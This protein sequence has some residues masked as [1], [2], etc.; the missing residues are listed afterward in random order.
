MR[1]FYYSFCCINSQFNDFLTQKIQK[2]EKSAMRNLKKILALALALVMSLSLMATANAFTDDDSITDTYET[3][4]TVLSG[5]KVFQGYDD[6]SFLPQGAITRAEVAAIIYRIVTGDVADTQVGI[7]ADY[8]KFDDVASTSWYAGYVNFCANAEYIKGYDARTFGPNDPVTGYQALAMI[9]RALGYDKNGEFTGTNWTIQTAAV[10]EQRGI[11]KNIT[12]GT[13]NVP[14]TRE[15]VAEILFRAILVNT[16]NY[17]PAFGYRENE[18]SLGWETF[19]LED[20]TGA[21]VLALSDAGNVTFETGDEA[22]IDTASKFESVTGLE[23]T[24]TTEQFVNFDGGSTYEASDWRIEYVINDISWTVT[25][26]TSENAEAQFKA[27]FGIDDDDSSVPGTISVAA[28]TTRNQWI[29]T[30]DAGANAAYE[31]VIRPGATIT[32]QDMNC[33]REIFYSADRNSAGANNYV[34]GEVY[35]GTQSTDDISDDADVSWNIFVDRYIETSENSVAIDDNVNGNWLKAIDNDGDGEAEYVLQVIYTVAGVQDISNSGTITLSNE[36]D[37]LTDGDAVNEITDDNAIVTEDELA[38]GDIVYYAVIDGN[39]Y[40]YLADVVTAEIDRVNRNDLSATTTDGDEYIESGVHEHT[41][42]DEIISGVR[43]LEGDVNYDLYLDRFGYLAAFTESDNNAGFVLLTDGYYETGRTEDTFAAMVWDREAQELV[44]TDITDGGELFIDTN[45]DDNDWGNLSEFV[46]INYSGAD[47]DIQTIVAALGEDG[48]LIPVDEV[49]RYRVN[50]AMIDMDTT[51][52]VRAHTENG[53]IYSTTRYGAYEQAGASVDVRALASTVYY[54]VYNTPLGNT[55]VREYVG[56][57]NIPDLGK[58]VNMI[59][60]VYV[61]GTRAEDAYSTDYYTAEIVVVELKDGYTEIDSEQVFLYD[62]PVAGSG[63]KYE[64][65]SVIRADGTVGTV[66]IDL[67]KSDFRSYDPA[68]GKWED[69]DVESTIPGLY[70]MWESDVADVYVVRPMTWTEIANSNYVVGTVL[71]D[72]ATGADD[73]TSFIAY[74]N[75]N[76]ENFFMF[77]PNGETE[78]RNTEDSN[79]YT[80]GY[81]FDEWSGP[82]GELRYDYSADFAEGDREDVLAQ[83]VD[84]DLNTVL[85]KYDGSNN[86]VYAISFNRW[87]DR[88]SATPDFAQ[89]V[90]AWNTPAADIPDQTTVTFYGQ[91]VAFAA[92]GAINFEYD[93]DYSEADADMDPNAIKVENG[94]IVIKNYT[95][96]DVVPG[97]FTYT[98]TIL[99]DDG[100]YYTFSLTQQPAGDDVGLYNIDG[101]DVDQTATTSNDLNVPGMPMSIANFVGQFRAKENATVT[102]EFGIRGGDPITVIADMNGNIIGGDDI[103]GNETTSEITSVKAVVTNEG[104]T[105]SEPYYDQAG[106]AAGETDAF[107]TAVEEAVAA[108]RQNVLDAINE[109]AEADELVFTE[110]VLNDTTTLGGKY[111]AYSLKTLLETRAANFAAGVYGTTPEDVADAVETTVGDYDAIAAAFL[112]AYKNAAQADADQALTDLVNPLYM[113]AVTVSET[114]TDPADFESAILEA[115]KALVTDP[116]ATV[117][118]TYGNLSTQ[119]ASGL[120]ANSGRLEVTGA[121]VTVDYVGASASIS[122]TLGTITVNYNMNV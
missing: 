29:V 68:D 109:A 94:T 82:Y 46:P 122:R 42:W 121:I 49:Y 73:W 60:D 65:A 57:A 88:A 15:V 72:T 56:Y 52:P 92:T 16:V 114:V 20:I 103:T 7:Y 34:L 118:M 120:S 96:T 18:T 69:W 45:G 32:T 48:S 38:E 51:I 27:Y 100:E 110:D 43:N 28:G 21:T 104:K 6:G 11:T 106:I 83:R 113:K 30:Y 8:N 19:E 76:N 79:Y 26:S 24:T 84:G 81:D 54:Y 62:L 91:E 22:D 80:L 3:A 93:I 74:V 85:V 98:G 35:V 107:E 63:V 14:A 58:D 105:D 2:E 108:M 55:V 97:G 101:T 87:D 117:T 5:L 50:V 116:K 75:N 31:Q 64:E 61:V 111:A 102:W 59:E 10:G 33:M 40:T 47:D 25:A 39:A 99:G 12:A 1:S 119:L 44:D 36:D 13:L 37:A 115:V 4:V 89:F 70:Y 41:G 53:T 66:T 95:V 86:I 112:T 78:K 71:R 90:W 23:R 67:S 17:T 77:E 9:L